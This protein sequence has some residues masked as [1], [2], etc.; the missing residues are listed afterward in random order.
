MPLA[1]PGVTLFGDDALSRI[2]RQVR[3]A[4][5]SDLA[6]A[7]ATPAARLRLTEQLVGRRDPFALQSV[8]R[9]VAKRAGRDP[10]FRRELEERGILDDLRE[11]V[12]GSEQ[13]DHGGA[14]AGG[15]R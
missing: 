14:V 11:R 10:W 8:D 9:I 4:L 12:F 5:A 15:R 3:I 1:E 6:E 2:R 7:V 13:A